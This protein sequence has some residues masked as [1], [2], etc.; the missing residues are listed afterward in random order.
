MGA[1]SPQIF[2]KCGLGRGG[3]KHS[4]EE[5]LTYS[6]AIQ[7]R[8]IAL[9]AEWAKALLVALLMR[10]RVMIGGLKQGL[11]FCLVAGSL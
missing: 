1:P 11:C 6:I 3:Y 2:C 4:Y 10:L 7:L 5:K 9:N 8:S